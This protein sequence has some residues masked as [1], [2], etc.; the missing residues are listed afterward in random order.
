MR[1]VDL[2]GMGTEYKIIDIV[3]KTIVAGT[4]IL[5]AIG[6][7]Y[8]LAGR[9]TLNLRRGVGRTHGSKIWWP[10]LDFNVSALMC[11]VL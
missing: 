8:P 7:I 9:Q 4:K 3:G 10:S 1:F 6:P 5:E 11:K 2:N